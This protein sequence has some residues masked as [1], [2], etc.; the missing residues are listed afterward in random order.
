MVLEPFSNGTALIVKRYAIICY[1]V[2]GNS[3]R[4]AHS[5]HIC[6]HY[7]FSMSFVE[8]S[9]PQNGHSR[10]ISRSFYHSSS[11]PMFIQQIVITCSLKVLQE[12]IVCFEYLYY[13]FRAK[14]TLCSLSCSSKVSPN[15]MIK[16]LLDNQENL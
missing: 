9:G 2:L 12:E 3:K 1:K 8:S 4:S 14:R 13:A 11:I 5:F 16:L 7:L 15:L 10:I 6:F